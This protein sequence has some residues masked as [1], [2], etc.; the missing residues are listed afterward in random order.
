MM[1]DTSAPSWYNL[2]D[3]S[4]TDSPAL[5]VY[6]DRVA[7]N[8]RRMVIIAGG[9]DRLRPHVKTHKIPEVVLMHLEMGIS[10]FK[11][12]TIAEAEML[13]RCGARDILLAYQPTGPKIERLLRLTWDFPAARF[14]VLVDDPGAA[15]AIAAACKTQRS[16]LHVYLDL[17]LGMH[18]TGIAPGE[19]EALVHHILGLPLLKWA[20]FH[21]YD[22]HIRD[23]AFD[24]RKQRCDAAFVAVEQL[25]ERLESA[26]IPVPEIGAGGTPTF[27]VHALREGVALSP[28]TCVLWDGGYSRLLPD[29]D[30]LHAAVLL[31]RVVSKPAPDRLCL[32][33]GHKSVAAENP[34]PRVYFFG[35][36][37]VEFLGQSEEH[38]IIS[39]AKR[40]AWQIGDVVYGIPHHICPTTALYESVSVVSEHR[41]AGSWRVLARDRS[42]G[43]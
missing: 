26:G 3:S 35:M 20:G 29:L 19:A 22:G 36:E 15:S 21:A 16:S 18:R 4:L 11:C 23:S 31:T 8:L 27:P 30:F 7:E 32:D 33:L 42:I 24:V 5:L 40:D 25:R 9:A 12:A 41:V 1:N 43:V 2:H 6:R 13:A 17:D 38:L 14:A 10:K 39:C 28:G 37:N 34:H